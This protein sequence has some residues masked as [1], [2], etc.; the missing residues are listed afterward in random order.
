MVELDP[1]RSARIA[2]WDGLV[3]SVVVRTEVVEDV[4][5]FA[6]RESEFGMIAFALEFGDDDERMTTWCSAKRR[7]APGSDS[8]TEVSRT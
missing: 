4:E 6:S 7:S 3:Q 2:D 1:Q 8:S 5:G